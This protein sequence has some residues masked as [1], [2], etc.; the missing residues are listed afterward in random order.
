V[1]PLARSTVERLMARDDRF[2]WE[3]AVLIACIRWRV[4]SA[5]PAVPF[6][7]FPRGEDI[8]VSL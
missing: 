3:P 6:S 4:P 1:L 7:P 5:T 8:R 2:S